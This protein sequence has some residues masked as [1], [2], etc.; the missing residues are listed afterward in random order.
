MLDG[1]AGQC[2]EVDDP[3][4]LPFALA[5]GQAVGAQIEVLE[6]QVEQL[7]SPQSGVSQDGEACVLQTLHRVGRIQATAEI[8]FQLLA[9]RAAQMARQGIW[10]GQG[11]QSKD[12]GIHRLI[13]DGYLSKFNLHMIEEWTPEKV[14]NAYFEDPA[15]WGKSVFYFLNSEQAA[16][17]HARL[18]A[19]GCSNHLVLGSNSNNDELISDFRSGKVDA[20]VNCM[21]LTEGFDCPELQTAWVRDS[22]RG[23]T[24]QMAGRAFRIHEVDG[25]QVRKHIVQSENTKWPISRTATP[26]EQY[27]LI[28]GQWRSL[29]PN[30]RMDEI[31]VAAVR[32]TIENYE[33]LPDFITKK[34]GKGRPVDQ[35]FG[36][37]Q[38]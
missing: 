15:K 4:P 32:R 34:S 28:D 11:F 35:D 18:L 7:T 10:S 26:E 23:P 22:S 8:G 17:C 13:S 9:L 27:K 5:Y 21:I 37:F 24:M 25:Q 1:L 3:I 36:W 16:E 12:A 38:N 30:K 2:R 33:P 19:G 29:K 31:A 20:L 14:T 6:L